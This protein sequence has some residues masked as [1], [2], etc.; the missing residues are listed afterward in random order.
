MMSGI[1]WG[2]IVGSILSAFIGFGIG[3]WIWKRMLEASE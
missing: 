2:I 3:K 1:L